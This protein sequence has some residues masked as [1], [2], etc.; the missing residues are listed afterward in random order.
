M[1]EPL[2][3]P[4]PHCRVIHGRIPEENLQ[5]NT[6]LFC[7]V[8]LQNIVWDGKNFLCLWKNPQQPSFVYDF[9]PKGAS[10]YTY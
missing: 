1:Q 9:L 2:R 8:C 5:V 3:C 4:N 7:P 6:R 10:A